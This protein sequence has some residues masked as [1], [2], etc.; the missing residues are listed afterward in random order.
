[1][2]EVEYRGKQFTL[3]EETKENINNF[4]GFIT[5]PQS[6]FG[7]VF[8][9]MCGNG[10]TTLLNAFQSAINYLV[11]TGKLSRAYGITIVD[12]KELAI[13]AS[14]DEVFDYVKKK[15]FLAIEDVGREP[16]EIVSY[17]NIFTPIG[18]ILEYRYANLLFTVL[19]TNLTPKEMREKYGY[20]IADRMNEMFFKIIFKNSSYRQ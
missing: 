17:G 14:K 19:T 5:A 3:D 4:A 18:D 12:A 1:M 20:R 10:K 9:G 13:Q 15:E 7:V 8:S 16:S 6:K 11:D 2:A